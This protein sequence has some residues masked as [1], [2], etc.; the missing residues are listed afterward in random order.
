MKIDE[1]SISVPLSR[2]LHRILVKVK[3]HEVGFEFALR[4]V[5][6]DGRPIPGLRI[7]N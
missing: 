3:N 1:D 4:L 2:G 7:W 6:A 5:T